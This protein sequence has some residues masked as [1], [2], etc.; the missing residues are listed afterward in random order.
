VYIP[1]RLPNNAYDLSRATKEM[2]P[3]HGKAPER[4]DALATATSIPTFPPGLRDVAGEL[5][6]L[7]T[8]LSSPVES[9][10]SRAEL[11]FAPTEAAQA[12]TLRSTAALNRATTSYE[13]VSLGFG[14]GSSVAQLSGTYTGAGAAASAT[15]LS[16]VVEADA[17]ITY[18]ES[19]V[20]FRV[21]DQTGATLFSYA[22]NLKA[23]DSVDLGSNIGL[24]VRFTEGTL[25]N[26]ESSFTNVSKTTASDVDAS[27]LFNDSNA[28]LR[29]R[30]E[31]GL[32]VSA[33]SFTINGK[34]IEVKADDSIT[35]VVRR[36]NEQMPDLVA[37]FADD[38]ITIATADNTRSS[39]ELGNDSSGFLAATKL[40]GAGT[41]TGYVSAAQER[42]A[43]STQFAAVR[44]GGFRMGS[45]FISVDPATDTL[46]SVLERMT[47]ANPRASAY[48]DRGADTVAVRGDD[49]EL[50]LS[51]DTS[52]F[53]A[54]IG[55]DGGRELNA[56]DVLSLSPGAAAR[57]ERNAAN[58]QAELVNQ[59]LAG[60][61]AATEE[62][63]VERAE[64]KTEK[65]EK[66]AAEDDSDED[67]AVE[68]RAT[69]SRA[70]AAY[71]REVEDVA[72]DRQRWSP[73]AAFSTALRS[74]VEAPSELSA[75]I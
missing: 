35:S 45:A 40:L 30:F 71:R 75:T 59:T 68:S 69:A 14:N 41:N 23:G 6:R 15:R 11:Q 18:S 21:T 8:R 36:I 1:V 9:R 55:L 66:K 44:A 39:I 7:L 12:S 16:I 46:V 38:K 24:Q 25:V 4:K 73:P 27:A 62:A 53:L 37:T 10:R 28:N 3:P 60:L 51:D 17:N 56:R 58:R 63:R 31:D 34:A 67:R 48:F 29:P 43:D 47:S 65:V 52:G 61:A 26:S 54:A 5:D 64:A 33:G 49:A 13:K 2:S 50:A 74:G 42:L 22:G 57:L 19:A 32:S 70:R 20:A 72:R